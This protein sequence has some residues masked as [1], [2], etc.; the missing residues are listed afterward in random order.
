MIMPAPPGRDRLRDR[1]DD[2]RV[3]ALTQTAAQ[4][5][6]AALT[7]AADDLPGPTFAPAVRASRDSLDGGAKGTRR[8]SVGPPPI[9]LGASGAGQH[10]H[11][12][13]EAPP[14]V[15]VDE[16]ELRL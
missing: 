6:R 11:A 9:I 13:E 7:G 8:V 5:K 16:R 3:C 15:G 14:V 12:P 10:G 2:G 1:T 4:T